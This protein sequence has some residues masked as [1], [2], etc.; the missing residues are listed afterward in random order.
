MRLGCIADDF[1]GATDLASILVRGGMRVVQRTGL[2]APGD[3][4]PQ[5]RDADAIVI[6]L[7]IRTAPTADAVRAALTAH[8][9]L[10]QAGARQFY[11]K[12][13][14]TF[15]SWFSGERRG[16]IGPVVEALMEATGAD[17]TVATPAFPENGRTVYQGHLFVHGQPLDESSMREHPLTPMT[18]AS[19][20]RVLQ[21]QTRH[22]VGLVDFAHVARGADAVRARC[23]QLRQEG[24]RIA[25][26]D[27]IRDADLL[28][29]APAL[30]GL[31]LLTGASGLALGLPA[32]FGLQP[33]QAAA[34]LPARRGHRAIVAGSCSR[35]TNAQ[36][37]AFVA[38]GGPAFRIDPLR[39]AAGEDVVGEALQWARDRLGREPLLVYSSSDPA[40]VR[41]VQAALGDEHAGE[42]VE[43]TIAAIARGLVQAGVGELVVAGGET[44]GA[45][46]QALG[47]ARMQVGPL[48]APGVPW[49]HAQ[50]AGAGDGLH[51]ALKSGNFGGP[52]LFRDAFA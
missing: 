26:L 46:V 15:D 39:L 52:A 2:P 14:S 17:F 51:I 25:I 40:G 4:L 38:G 5:D 28:A 36:V 24:K 18:D 41:R 32:N 48:I 19:L 37:Q 27:A 42:L 21:A 23:A 31:P 33:S 45:C 43:Q 12:Y 49:C 9:W 29:I 44:S 11:Y 35:A 8:A 10:R 47:I 30:S 50:Q 20:V 34:R 13:C 6:A 3:V 22:A 16:N 7:K 1:T